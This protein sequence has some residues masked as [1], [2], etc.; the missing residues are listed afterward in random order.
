MRR[1][2]IWTDLLYISGRAL[3][4]VHANRVPE[5]SLGPRISPLQKLYYANVSYYSQCRLRNYRC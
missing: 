3:E 2:A 5:C 1:V 4:S